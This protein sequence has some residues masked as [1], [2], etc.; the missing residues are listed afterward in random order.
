M[1][2]IYTVGHG[3]ASLQ[4]FRNV[5]EAAEITLVVDVRSQPYSRW[6]PQYSRKELSY[7]LGLWSIEYQW[8][9]ANLGGRGE[10]IRFP[11]TVQELAVLASKRTIALMCS[12]GHPKLCHRRTM[13][14]PAFQ[15]HGLDVVHL[16]HD[17]TGMLDPGEPLPSE[18]DTLF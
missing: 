1:T 18:P 8:K 12:E 2:T 9:G 17:G 15:A 3:A 7:S 5:L 10:N 14:A 16:L 13:L 4:L 11:E 6:H